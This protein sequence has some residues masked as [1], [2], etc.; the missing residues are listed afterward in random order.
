V[1]IGLMGWATSGKDSFG[2]FLVEDGYTRFAFADGVRDLAY[3]IDPYVLL[4]N[5]RRLRKMVDLVGWDKAKQVPEVRSLLQRIGNETREVCGDDVW[6]RA[7]EKKMVGGPENVVITDVRYRNEAEFIK[8]KGGHLFRICRLG[9]GPLNDHISENDLNDWPADV[10]IHN[11]TDLED[12]KTLAR[13][14][15]RE[16]SATV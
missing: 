11:D 3:R 8:A 1:L 5:G 16:L 7:V 9:V 10:D 13:I 6:I 14:S 2:G 4:S 12:L 15:V